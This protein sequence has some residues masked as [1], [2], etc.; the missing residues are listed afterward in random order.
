MPFTFNRLEIPEVILVTPTIY[1]DPRGMFVET[2]KYSEF[3]HGGIAEQF[4]QD[5]QSESKRNVLRG[6]HYQ[7][8]PAAQGKL[9]RCTGGRIFDVAVDLRKS[10]PTYKK[11]LGIE[12]SDE[13]N[14][15]LYIPPAFA[16]GFVALSDE[17]V[18]SYKCTREYSREHDAGVRWDDPSIGVKWPGKEFLV[19]EKDKALP[20]LSDGGVGF[21]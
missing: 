3:A 8:N 7:K 12:L 19:S 17:A 20:L 21:P 2:Y 11:W 9:V 13:N 1:R 16:H 14:Y 15:M 6:L 4:V 5:N 10:S 18:V